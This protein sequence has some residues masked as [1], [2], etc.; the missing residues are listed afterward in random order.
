MFQQIKA[1][2]HFNTFAVY[3]NIYKSPI[4]FESTK[5][6]RKVQAFYYIYTLG[7]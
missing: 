5:M 3:Q 6:K 1:W 2:Y 7:V 4:P